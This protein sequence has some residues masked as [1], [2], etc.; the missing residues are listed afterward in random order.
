MTA[1]DYIES[2]QPARTAGLH[3]AFG[4]AW[5]KLSGGAVEK[6]GQD[7]SAVL[8]A[9]FEIEAWR[10]WLDDAMHLLSQSERSRVERKLR[11]SD[12]EELVL[13]YALHR[14]VLGH[15]LPCDPAKIEL[16]RDT[17]G[18]PF[19]QGNAL[20]TSL[21]HT[22]GAVAVAVTRQGFVGID[23]EPA[24]RAQELPGIASS[25]LHSDE[26]EMLSSMQEGS[27]ASAL[28][29]LWVR[30]EALLKASGIGLLREMHSFV[31]PAG[32][33]VGLPAADGT[34]GAAATLHMLE[35][36][37]RWVAAIAAMPEARFQACWL[38]PDSKLSAF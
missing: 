19:V 34:D 15:F 18:R 25:V 10:P 3:V 14:L 20:G 8:V 33:P 11:Q 37:S 26:V 6:H 32:R 30:K 27:R 29:A 2:D 38:L 4:S 24:L 22:Q 13:A 31:A 35:A 23:I 7:T 1:A 17:L 28:L 21:S 16:E 5:S 12:R 9:L 36:G